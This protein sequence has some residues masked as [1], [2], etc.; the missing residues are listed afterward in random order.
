MTLPLTRGLFISCQKIILR[1]SI[2]E[3]F[4]LLLWDELHPQTQ[5]IYPP[6]RN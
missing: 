2:K 5:Q 6:R 3:L 4:L 1:P